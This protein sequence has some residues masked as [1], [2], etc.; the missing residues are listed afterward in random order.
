[1]TPPPPKKKFVL[2]FVEEGRKFICLSSAR[3][4]YDPA[5]LCLRPCPPMGGSKILVGVF[6]N[7]HTHIWNGF[8]SILPMRTRYLKRT[9]NVFYDVATLC[10]FHAENISSNPE[11][12]TSGQCMKVVDVSNYSYKV[13]EPILWGCPLYTATQPCTE[14]NKAQ[15]PMLPWIALY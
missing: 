12:S 4:K 5:P 2:Y 3:K 11:I 6:L 1:M 13:Y 7:P 8:S 9:G 14:C 10:I 15:N